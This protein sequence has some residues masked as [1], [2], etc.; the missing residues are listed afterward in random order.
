MKK[1][2]FRQ[3]I[4][5]FDIFTLQNVNIF[6]ILDI[7]EKFHPY[8][9]FCSE[10]IFFSHKKLVFQKIN[11]FCLIITKYDGIAPKTPIFMMVLVKNPDL[12]LFSFFY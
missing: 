6:D 4:S 5:D 7:V 8:L 10:K 2:F 12:D 11:I 3:K 9:R 1:T